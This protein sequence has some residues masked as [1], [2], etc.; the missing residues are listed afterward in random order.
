[1]QIILTP[2]NIYR[3]LSGRLMGETDFLPLEQKRSLI[4]FYRYVLNGAVSRRTLQRLFPD[5]GPRPRIQS[6]LMNRSSSASLPRFLR[7]E[8]EK[9]SPV[10]ALAR[11]LSGLLGGLVYQAESLFQ[12]ITAFEDACFQQ[13]FFITPQIREFLVSLRHTPGKNEYNRLVFLCACRLAWLILFSFYGSQMNDSFLARQCFETDP[14]KAWEELRCQGAVPWKVLSAADTVGG[15]QP[16]PREQYVTLSVTPETAA[17]RLQRD[18]RLLLSGMGGSGKTEL[19]RQAL[20]LVTA[21]QR[22]AFVQVETSLTDGFRAAFPEIDEKKDDQFLAAVRARLEEASTLLV[23][24]QAAGNAD[25]TCLLDWTCDILATDRRPELPGFSVLRLESLDRDASER[26]LR[27]SAGLPLE[28][29]SAPSAE[30]LYRFTGG[31]PLTLTILG[32]L[33]RAHYWS[34]QQLADRLAEQGFNDLLLPREEHEQSLP[35]FMSRLMRLADLDKTDERLLR[36]IAMFS[37]RA[38]K[39]DELNGLTTA[40]RLRSLSEKNLLQRGEQGYLMHPVIAETIRAVPY[41][42]DEFPALWKRWADELDSAVSPDKQP[43]FELALAALLRCG[44]RMNRD[45]VTVLTNIERTAMTRGA[46]LLKHDLP[47]LHQQWLDSSPHT[48][49][50][51]ITLHIIHML[52]ACLG[53]RDDYAASAAALLQYPKEELLCH[54][55]YEL[56]LN[57]LEIGGSRISRDLLNRLFDLLQPDET[58]PDQMVMYLNFLGG[59][60][61]TLDKQPELALETLAKARP[62]I[63]PGSMKEAA[64][65]TR[66]AYCL[67]DLNRWQETLPLMRRV[68]DNFRAR[69]YAE[70]SQTMVST[71]NSY[72]YFLG[73]CTD[74]QR[75]L[76]EL[77]ISIEAMRQEGKEQTHDF[78]CALQH[79]AD[80]LAESGDFEQAETVIREALTA[81]SGEISLQTGSLISAAKIYL[82]NGKTIEALGAASLALTLYEKHYGPENENTKKARD[83][84]AEILRVLETE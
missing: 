13:D 14:D 69:G 64:N 73:K 71:R 21:Y 60:Q 65:D 19:A 62:W 8:F 9:Q 68:M 22:A 41:S 63:K 46:S 37:L 59:K 57:V 48:T 6:D 83:L 70:D 4:Q 56:L 82:R 15:R 78:F 38:W 31:H 52:W 12:T 25:L 29:Q 32:A 49:E 10:P 79:Y 84:R 18:H 16:L 17:Y 33:C 77:Q 39:P 50:D 34:E 40:E 7:E 27:L 28:N 2:K 44:P 43:V 76:N 42:A 24:D 20:P 54:P 74:L 45:A 75:A 3:V 67:A 26:L 30:T 47:A 66:T 51:E 36:Y 5:D 35:V 61:R 53:C 1:M 80:L 23:I 11:N 81:P 58:N 55:R 72:Q